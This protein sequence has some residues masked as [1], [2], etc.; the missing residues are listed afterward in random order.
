MMS[1]RN[2]GFSLVEIAIVLVIFGLLLGS[3]LKGQ[4]LI[5]SAKA[6]S[7]A[8]DARNT[9]TMLNAYQDRFRAIPGDD[10][11]AGARF[12]TAAPLG[13][14]GNGVIEGGWNDVSGAESSLA[15]Q[16]LRLANLAPGSGDAPSAGE[17]EPRNAA[18]GR[19]GLQ[20]QPP[21]PGMRGRLF[22]CQGNI[23]GRVAQQVDT[24]LDDGRPN[25]GSVRFGLEIGTAT[26]DADENLVYIICSSA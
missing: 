6:K 9:L 12:G 10:R 23:S 8:A 17:W 4:D 25:S 18:G 2:A 22:I 13:G 19:I 26:T 3:V 21:F 11:S 1:V 7:V 24:S 14:N 15:W 20:S 5:D 16:H